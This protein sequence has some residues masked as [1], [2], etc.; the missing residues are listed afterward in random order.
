VS[1]PDRYLYIF[2]T[3]LL[4]LGA[5]FLYRFIRQVK[6]ESAQATQQ[7]GSLA[8]SMQPLSA[9]LEHDTGSVILIDDSGTV[10]YANSSTRP[11]LGLE[12]P[13]V[14][15]PAGEL[16]EQ[17]HPELREAV[18][19]G[20]E[21]IVS[22]SPN[23]ADETLL[24]TSRPLRIEGRP[25]FMYTLRPITRE[26]RRQ[27][28]ENWKKLIRVLSHEINNTLAPIASLVSTAKRLGVQ[29]G[30]DPRLAEVLDAIGER[31]V[32]LSSFLESYRSLARL[33]LPS[34]RTVNW[35]AFLGT[36]AQER[37]FKIIEPIP[38]NPGY[39][40][41]V[42]LERVL[43]NTIDN[44][45][46]AGSPIESVEVQ[47]E[48]V[49]EM[50][51]IEVFDRGSGMSEAVLRQAMLPFFSTKSTGTGIGLALSREIVEAHGGELSL[52]NR[53]GGGLVVTILLP[54]VPSTLS[55][56]KIPVLSREG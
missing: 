26:V 52:A 31:T 9:A 47:V 36:L 19:S 23:H 48:P 38:E 46:E 45:V 53:D 39:F 44:A 5:V 16:L 7:L 37:A 49:G 54:C 6:S 11:L 34:P 32:H 15:R 50:V 33:P 24:V 30:G 1:V 35:D 4:G 21:G 3:V 43:V 14:G 8:R 28:L 27:E 20:I 18:M 29:S 2:P 55:Q 25:H 13:V 40:D 41:P 12:G 17:L 56:R 42:Q 22:R 51:R 10:I